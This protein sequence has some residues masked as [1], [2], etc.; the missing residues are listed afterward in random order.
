MQMK[1]RAKADL[2]LAF[3][4][5]ASALRP[6]M[7]QPAKAVSRTESLSKPSLGNGGFRAAAFTTFFRRKS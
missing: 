6:D 5:P 7:A 3:F 1:W 4:F 2:P